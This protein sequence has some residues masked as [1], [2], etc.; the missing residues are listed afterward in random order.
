MNRDGQEK[1]GGICRG[2]KAFKGSNWHP[3]Q[4]TEFMRE[5]S[6][7]RKTSQENY[8]EGVLD[9]NGSAHVEGKAE[10]GNVAGKRGKKKNARWAY[11]S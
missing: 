3:R 7:S 2:G 6:V 11:R 5:A 1:G 9:A 8:S 10:E 4:K